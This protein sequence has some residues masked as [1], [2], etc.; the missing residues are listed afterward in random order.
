MPY[1]NDIREALN[2]LREGF[3]VVEAQ[4]VL[5]HTELQDALLADLERLADTRANSSMAA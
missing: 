2:T 3:P 5:D 4:A 1:W